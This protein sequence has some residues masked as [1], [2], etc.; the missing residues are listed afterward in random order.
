MQN[1]TVS[2]PVSLRRIS[3]AAAPST[4][5]VDGWS[6]SGVGRRDSQDGSGLVDG[7]PSVS[8]LRIAV[9]GRQ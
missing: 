3:A 8:A 2:V 9:A 5:C 4:L 6:G 1:A 7:L